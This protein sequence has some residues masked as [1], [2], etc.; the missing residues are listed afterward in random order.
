MTTGDESEKS[1]QFAKAVSS[2]WFSIAS[3]I[4]Q[5]KHG[6][7]YD[8]LTKEEV[9]HAIEHTGEP[10]PPIVRPIIA[11]MLLGEFK[12]VRGIK[13]KP[14]VIRRNAVMIFLDLVETANS[15]PRFKD[16]RPLRGEMP[17]REICLEAIAQAY[18]VTPRTLEHWIKDQEIICL[19]GYRRDG[20]EFRSLSEARAY[21]RNLLARAKY[22]TS[23]EGW[24][25]P[26]LK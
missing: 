6:G 7:P 23:L 5:E 9:A 17:C 11:Q 8:P 21:E 19:E 10:P 13:G 26:P 24:P 18:C 1:K 14:F 12:S 3:K 22:R 16:R 2:P 20:M 4:V 25:R 15:D